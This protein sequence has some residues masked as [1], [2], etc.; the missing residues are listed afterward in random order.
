[1]SNYKLGNRR[2]VVASAVP[3][4][5]SAKVRRGLVNEPRFALPRRSYIRGNGHDFDF[6][7]GLAVI[8]IA[9]SPAAYAAI[10]ATRPFIRLLARSLGQDTQILHGPAQFLNI[11]Y[12]SLNIA[13]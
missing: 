1:M 5:A 2:V 3:F 8:R 9:I 4:K 11:R 13:A 7:R 10:A 6:G 12:I